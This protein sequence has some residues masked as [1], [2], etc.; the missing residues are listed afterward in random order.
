MKTL[1]FISVTENKKTNGLDEAL[2]DIEY[3][4]VSKTMTFDR[5]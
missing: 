4:R 1:P 5:I 2:K 3:G